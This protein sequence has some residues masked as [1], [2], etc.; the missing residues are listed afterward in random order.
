MSERYWNPEEN[1]AFLAAARAGRPRL[2]VIEGDG[3]PSS[4]D[5]LA[6]IL[7]ATEAFHR[8]YVA[9]SEPQYVGVTLWT[10]HTH[11]IGATSTTPYLHLTS[12]EPECG[13]TRQLECLEALT[14]GPM[15][16]ASVTPAVLYRAIQQLSPTLLIDEADNVMKDK[17][18]KGDMFGV[19]NAGYRRGAPAYRMGGGN[20]DN[21]EKFETFCPKAIAGLDALVAT[22]ASRCLRIDMQRR[23]ADEPVSDFFREDAHE[24][25]A[26]IREALAAWGEQSANEL[27]VAR[28][29][30]LGVR[31]RME[32]AL[33]L[34]VAIAE[35]AG[36][37]WA[38]RGR[39]AL[40]ELAGVSSTGATSENVQLL[41]DIRVV[42]ERRGNPTQLPT[43]DLLEGLLELDEAPW[44]GWW[45]TEDKDGEVH[46]SKGA[47]RKLSEKLR[48]FHIAS[49]DMGPTG[50]RHKGYTRADLERAW[51]RWLPRIPQAN[52]RNPRIPH[53]KAKNEHPES[54]HPG[55]GCADIDTPQTRITEPSARNARNE[56]GGMAAGLPSGGL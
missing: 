32:E 53:G 55:S 17:D 15:Y 10:A 41:T 8:R 43:A 6:G 31:D 26:P 20:R 30:R 28:P 35:M 50:G 2:H 46:P 14:P 36:E 27:R 42:F 38:E 9:L 52:P 22:L 18:A 23:T 29:E 16:A 3:G 24:E 25:A 11:V 1:A 44:R 45:G 13:K 4:L 39:E 21:L 7:S 48:G 51:R 19:L 47:A 40:R 56:A 5:C 37:S 54:A 12:P 34:L 33:R 49:R